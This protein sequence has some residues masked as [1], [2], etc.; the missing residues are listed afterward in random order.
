[1]NLLWLLVIILIVA[2]IAYLIVNSRKGPRV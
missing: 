2:L 1:M